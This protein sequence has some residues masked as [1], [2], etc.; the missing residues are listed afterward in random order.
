[1]LHV[2]ATLDRS[3]GRSRSKAGCSKVGNIK[4]L[5]KLNYAIKD[6][7]Q[8]LHYLKCRFEYF[9]SL[10]IVHDCCVSWYRVLPYYPTLEYCLIGFVPGIMWYLAS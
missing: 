8:L 10:N 7:H 9:T 4:V 2:A 3:G 1:M 6:C 5:D